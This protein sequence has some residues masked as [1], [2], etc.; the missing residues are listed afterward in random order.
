MGSR[1]EP[2]FQPASLK[3][4]PSETDKVSVND[5][6]DP[7]FEPGQSVAVTLLGQ[8]LRPL[9]AT[10]VEM[11]GPAVRLRMSQT[12]TTGT[13]VKIE[14]AD[15]LLLADVSFCDPA[16]EGAVVGVTVRHMLTALAELA[17]LGR[18]LRGEQEPAVTPPETAEKIAVRH[19]SSRIM[20]E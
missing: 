18:A 17:R 1:A 3:F 10:V 11:T 15:T 20:K 2:L 12:L 19:P 4:P 8:S 6:L 9:A 16:P 13:A 5:T 14:G 7:V